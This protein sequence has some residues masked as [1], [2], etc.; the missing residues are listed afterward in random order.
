MFKTSI[1]AL[2]LQLGQLGTCYCI[3]QVLRI[4]ARVKRSVGSGKAMNVTN[5]DL[6]AQWKKRPWNAARIKHGNPWKLKMRFFGP[7]ITSPPVG[8]LDCKPL[9]DPRVCFK[10]YFKPA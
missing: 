7:V 8:A 6:L 10:N 9:F 5:Y 3:V 4:F 2:A 1:L